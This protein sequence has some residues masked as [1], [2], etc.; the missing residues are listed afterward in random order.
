MIGNG[1]VALDVARMLALTPEELAPTDT[2][3]AAI[4][5]IVAPGVQEIVVLGRRG[6]CRPRGRTPELGSW[7]SS[8]A[9]TWSSTRPSSSSTRRARP[10]SRRRTRTRS[11]TSRSCATSPRA[12]RAGKPRTSGS[13]PRLAGRDPR[14][15][16]GRGDRARRATALER[17]RARLASAPSRPT[18]ARR[19]SAASSSAASATAASRSRACRSTSARMIPNEGGRVLDD[20][21]EPIPA[22]T[23]PAGSSAGRPASSGRTRR[24]PPRRSSCCSRTRAAGLLP[25]PADAPRGRVEALVL[26]R[27]ARSA[28]H[29]RG[30][31]GDRRAERAAGE[32]HGRPR[33]KLCT[34]DELLAAARG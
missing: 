34:W 10:S 3:D 1:N 26:E 20:A 28:V 12:S 25:T 9:P 19:S 31:G 18:S 30:L 2:T 13:L 32:P 27:E 16:A 8:P 24:T 23:A 4:E 17:R 15:G 33:V 22:S 11:A 21:G 29:V 7:A 6:P 5:A 14:R